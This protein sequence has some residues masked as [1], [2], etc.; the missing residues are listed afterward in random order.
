ML[1]PN[2]LRKD[3]FPL[4]EPLGARVVTEAGNSGKADL[5]KGGGVG[6]LAVL[7]ELLGR[8]GTEDVA[9]D[10]EAEADALA[11]QGVVC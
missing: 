8:L 9:R 4:T 10:P 6:F 3:W 1:S 7:L 5:D 2:I 11:D